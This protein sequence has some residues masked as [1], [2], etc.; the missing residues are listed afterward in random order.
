MFSKDIYQKALQLGIDLIAPCNKLT[1]GRKL[2]D[3]IDN[4]A[5]PIIIMDEKKKTLSYRLG[6]YQLSLDTGAALPPLRV[7]VVWSAEQSKTAETSRLKKVSKREEELKELQKK[8][9]TPRYKKKSAV[10]KKLQ[11]IM[12][13]D[14]VNDGLQVNLTGEDEHVIMI[15]ESFLLSLPG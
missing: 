2:L 15:S 10:E 11:K 5:L 3:T 14:P 6:E 12:G 4:D 9:N 8:L 13:T 7:S 1:E